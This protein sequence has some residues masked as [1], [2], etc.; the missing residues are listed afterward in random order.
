M[1]DAVQGQKRIQDGK[2]SS[3]LDGLGYLQVLMGS[4]HLALTALSASFDKRN[5]A[6]IKVPGLASQSFSILSDNMRNFLTLVSV[7]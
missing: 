1:L 5:G 2:S 4:I 7:S 3:I 6:L